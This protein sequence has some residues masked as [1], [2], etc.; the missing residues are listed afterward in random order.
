MFFPIEMDPN[1]QICSIVQNGDQFLCITMIDW[2]QQNQARIHLGGGKAQKVLQC[3]KYHAMNME[4]DKSMK[5]ILA[6]NI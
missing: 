6:Q 4:D 3:L 5:N 2:C 1:E